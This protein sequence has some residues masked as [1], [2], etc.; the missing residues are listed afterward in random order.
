MSNYEKGRR[1]E[2]Y[3][4]DK[5]REKGYFCERMASSKPFDLLASD[6]YDSFAIEV[7]SY[8]PSVK[9]L[10]NMMIELQQI[11]EETLLVP[12]LICKKGTRYAVY[13][14]F[15]SGILA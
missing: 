9:Q 1:A 13:P 12:I 14:A 4:R 2:Y 5:L 11:T 10:E 6:Q 8:Q 3:I 7:K 15:R